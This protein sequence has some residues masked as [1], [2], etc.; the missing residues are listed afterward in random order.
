MIITPSSD[1]IADVLQAADP[2]VQRAA[3]AKLDAMEPTESD[4]GAVL[5]S[6]TSELAAAG[7]GPGDSQ[8]VRSDTTGDVGSVSATRVINAAPPAKAYQKFEAFVLQVFVESMLPQ[9]AQDVF[10]KGIAGG[11]WRSM[12]AEQLGN[13]LAEGKGIG[14]AKRLAAAHPPDDRGTQD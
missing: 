3:A 14:I 8:T 1:L 12:L 4:F 5:D 10:G 7:R 9:G 6:R 13:Q 2:T 11:I